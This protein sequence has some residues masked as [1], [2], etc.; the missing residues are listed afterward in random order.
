MAAPSKIT[1]TLE[2]NEFILTF[3]VSGNTVRFPVD[4]R[5]ARAMA[6]VL[7]ANID[8]STCARTIGTPSAPVQYD[9]ETM[10]REMPV[11]VIPSGTTG[12]AYQKL[13]DKSL[14]FELDLSEMELKS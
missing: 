2:D 9:I 10:I 14:D 5:G 11:T 8:Q 12:A 13:I 4:D 3:P 7:Q 6:T 1:I